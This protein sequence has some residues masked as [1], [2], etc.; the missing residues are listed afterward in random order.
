MPNASGNRVCARTGRGR[1]P[2]A[3]ASASPVGTLITNSERHPKAWT[4]TPPRLGP[5]AAASAPAALHSATDLVRCSAGV[6]ANRIAS[7]AGII[8]AAIAPWSPRATSSS[9]RLGANAQ[10]S[11]ISAKPVTP[12]RYRVRRPITSAR[13]P[14]G[15]SSAA[16]SVA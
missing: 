5:T 1:T 16:N 7:D 4:S 11:D 10:A 14:A 9:G 6:S 3:A 13:R 12:T 8:S 15:A 2:A